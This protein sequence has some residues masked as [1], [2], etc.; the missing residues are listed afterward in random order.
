MRLRNL[1]YLYSN[2]HSLRKGFPYKFNEHPVAHD[3]PEDFD[4][5]DHDLKIEHTEL[6]NYFFR[7]VSKLF[8]RE[9]FDGFKI[10]YRDLLQSFQ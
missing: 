6:V 3:T 10:A 1:R 2:F 7:T 4:S 5:D 9:V 8:G